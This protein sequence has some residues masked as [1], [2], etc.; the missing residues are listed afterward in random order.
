MDRLLLTQTQL[1]FVYLSAIR[2]SGTVRIAVH[3][4]VFW[5]ARQG[6]SGIMAAVPVELISCGHQHPE[7]GYFYYIGDYRYAI[8]KPCNAAYTQTV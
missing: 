1:I 2:I 5:R 8:R 3:G 6:L 4:W 7:N